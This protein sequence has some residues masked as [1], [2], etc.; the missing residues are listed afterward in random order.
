MI[1]GAIWKLYSRKERRGRAIRK[2]RIKLS[3]LRVNAPVKTDTNVRL[4]AVD[5]L[6]IENLGV[7]VVPEPGKP[8]GSY[9]GQMRDEI[10]SCLVIFIPLTVCFVLIRLGS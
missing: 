7:G 1:V 3:F 4:L 2:R 9:E 8:R 10:C 5:L 6:C